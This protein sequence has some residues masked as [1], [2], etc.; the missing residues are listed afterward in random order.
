MKSC[1][2]CGNRVA[3]SAMHCTCG[4]EVSDG[5]ELPGL[6]PMAAPAVMAKPE[7]PGKS[8]PHCGGKVTAAMGHCRCGY[9]FSNGPDIPGLP[10]MSEADQAFLFEFGVLKPT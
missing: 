1:P 10:P 9:E 5:P 7:A 2:S 8:C 6:S 4:F 3:A